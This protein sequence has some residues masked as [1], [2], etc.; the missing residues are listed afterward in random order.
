VP[1]PSVRR[2]QIPGKVKAPA[3]YRYQ[4]DIDRSGALDD[5]VSREGDR[6]R[7]ERGSMDESPSWVR[8]WLS[9]PRLASYVAIAGPGGALEFYA[10]N[11]RASTALFELIG[12]FEV[13]WRNNI[14]RAICAG[15][16]VA[17]PHWLFDR[18]F[19]LQPGTRAKVEAAVVKARRTTKQPTPGQVIA[20]L[21]LGF[22]RFTAR[23]YWTSI[24]RYLNHA[25]PHA[26]GVPHA[27]DL[28]RK[29]DAIIK[30]RNRIAHHEPLGPVG[31]LCRQVEQI[32]EI[33]AWISPDMADWWRD[34]TSVREAL[35]CR[36]CE[37]GDIT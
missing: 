31:P 35:A 9:P 5:H 2:E 7:T 12:W 11:C 32:L 29:L 14:D 13:A 37:R 33:G 20:E 8:D 1:V 3:M 26:P 28:D 10:W 16:G 30:L 4:G 34:R 27:A 21:S 23:G 15:R 36:P 19:P 17:A 24:W 6:V 22:W 25:F 18:S